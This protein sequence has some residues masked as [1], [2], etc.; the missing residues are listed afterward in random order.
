[1]CEQF[2]SIRILNRKIISVLYVLKINL[3][4]NIVVEDNNSNQYTRVNK[5]YLPYYFGME[6]F[7]KYTQS[8]FKLYTVLL[9]FYHRV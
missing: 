9:L 8:L 3:K 4:V 1:L 2:K 6:L 7:L 5:T